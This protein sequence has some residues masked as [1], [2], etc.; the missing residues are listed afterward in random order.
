MTF[1]GEEERI[2]GDVLGEQTFV[3]WSLGCC[4]VD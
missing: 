3:D 1:G 2:V 4:F